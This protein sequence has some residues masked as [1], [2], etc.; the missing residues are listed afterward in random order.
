MLKYFYRLKES[1]HFLWSWGPFPIR[2]PI[3]NIL[4]I[5]CKKNFHE[6]CSRVE[7][8]WRKNQK[9]QKEKSPFSFAK[10][11]KKRTKQWHQSERMCFMQ[12]KRLITV[13]DKSTN[14][15][16]NNQPTNKKRPKHPLLGNFGAFVQEFET[17]VQMNHH[18]LPNLHSE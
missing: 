12:E 4:I 3:Y 16:L 7:Y 1:K 14:P 8:S 17:F 5:F 18:P 6:W 9:Y 10:K 15:P 13:G 2:S 11:T